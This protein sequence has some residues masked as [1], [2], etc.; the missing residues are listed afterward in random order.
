VAGTAPDPANDNR[1]TDG[2]ASPLDQP[3]SEQST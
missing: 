2:F 1:P 3:V